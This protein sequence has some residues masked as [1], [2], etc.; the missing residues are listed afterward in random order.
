MSAYFDLSRWGL[1]AGFTS[2]IDRLAED[3]AVDY[4]FDPA[5]ADFVVVSEL[6]GCDPAAETAKLRGHIV[7]SLEGEDAEEG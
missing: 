2:M 7:V 6:K 5:E 4:E 1:F 3:E